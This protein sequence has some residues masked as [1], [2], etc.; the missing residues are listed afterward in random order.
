M[1]DVEG[2]VHP[3]AGDA[4]SGLYNPLPSPVRICDTRAGDPLG[5]T[6]ANAQCLGERISGGGAIAVQVAGINGVPNPRRRWSWTP[7]TSIQPPLGS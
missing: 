6:G 4:P 3:P 1:V 2:F 7:P 5:L